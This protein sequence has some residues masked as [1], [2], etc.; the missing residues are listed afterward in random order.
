MSD[1]SENEK[2]LIKKIGENSL[3]DVKQLL[4]SS[5]VRINCC[6]ENGMNALQHSSYKGNYEITKYLLERGA[7]VNHNQHIHGYTALMFAALG[8]HQKVVN[9]LLENGANVSAVNSVGRNASQMAAFVGQH[10]TV[11]IINNFISR[12][13]IEYYTKIHG[14]ET[15]PRLTARLVS[16]LH[17]FV[18]QTNIHPI[19]IGLYLKKN[20]ILIENGNK[21][22]KVLEL[23]CERQ[24]KSNEQNEMISI[25]LHHLAF[26]FNQILKYLSKNDKNSDKN[27]SKTD[28]NK[29]EDLKKLD[30]LLKSWLK[31]RQSD[32]FPLLLEQLLRQSIR[33]FPYH[34]SALFQQLVRTLA[35]VEIGSEPS[36]VS[37][38]SQAI[39]GQKGFD[40]DSQVCGACAEPNPSKRCSQC[41]QMSYCDVECQRLHWSSHKKFCKVVPQSEP[42]ESHSS[43]N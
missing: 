17:S 43:S 1:L 35:N 11:A 37:I 7:D 41:K 25:K 22:I 16:P 18:R 32:G 13:S 14:L 33:E 5:D 4:N 30:T 31:P 42:E 34:E 24:L 40:E 29:E 2:L 6:D 28:N 23:L 20:W 39:N 12:E 3:E 10:P 36:A 9:L 15:E 26:I 27:E 38:L 8:G 19:R 21:I